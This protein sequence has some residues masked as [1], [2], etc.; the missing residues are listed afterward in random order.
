[1]IQKVL[2]LGDDGDL[3]ADGPKAVA[4]LRRLEGSMIALMV[5]D[6][7]PQQSNKTG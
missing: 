1:M 3:A 4:V 6:G 7:E 2:D 5:M